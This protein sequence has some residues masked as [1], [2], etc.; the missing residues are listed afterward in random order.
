MLEIC[1][2]YNKLYY[3]NSCE[4]ELYFFCLNLLL[5]MTEDFEVEVQVRQAAV[6]LR[7]TELFALVLLSLSKPAVKTPN[8]TFCWKI[9]ENVG[10]CLNGKG[11]IELHRKPAYELSSIVAFRNN[12]ILSVL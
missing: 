7:L 1:S 12:L 9:P 11:E 5:F 2:E 8:L 3:S 10:L 6:Y 4:V